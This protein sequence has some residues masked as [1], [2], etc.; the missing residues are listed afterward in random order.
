MVWRGILNGY[1]CQSGKKI[2]R[3]RGGGERGIYPLCEWLSLRSPPKRDKITPWRALLLLLSL[4]LSLSLFDIMFK[5]PNRA[6]NIRRKV[7]TSD[8]E[9]KEGK[10]ATIVYFDPNPP[11]THSFIEPVIVNTPLKSKADKKKAKKSLGLSFDQQVMDNSVY[12]HVS[13]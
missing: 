2:K 12:L 11:L 5:K 7:E 13:I 9:S 1:E 4:S 10:S 8:D 6:K 3:K